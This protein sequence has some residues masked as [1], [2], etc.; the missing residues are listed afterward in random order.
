M[1]AWGPDACRGAPRA[2]LP[3][4]GSIADITVAADLPRMASSCR[5]LPGDQGQGARNLREQE[6]SAGAIVVIPGNPMRRNPHPFD[7][8]RYGAHN[9]TERMLCRLTQGL[10]THRNPRR[11]LR[12]RRRAR[13][14]HHLVGLMESRP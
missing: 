13:R 8:S 9:A 3:S 10:L 12:I 1:P 5:V 14:R 11:P 4:P 2:F 6:A 7:A